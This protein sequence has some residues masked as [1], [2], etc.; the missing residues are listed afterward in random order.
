LKY[1][2]YEELQYTNFLFK[3]GEK[4]KYIYF[5][6]FGK[7]EIFCNQTVKNLCSM[8][9]KISQDYII[10]PTKIE[11]YTKI[12]NDILDRIYFCNLIKKEFLDEIE[13]KLLVLTD[14]CVL[15]MESTLNNLPYLYNVKILSEKCGYYKIE[16][17]NLLLLMK[18]VKDGK[19]IINHIKNSHLELILDRMVNICQKKVN[20]INNKSKLKKKKKYFFYHN[21]NQNKNEIKPKI[22]SNKIKDFLL[23]KSKKFKTSIITSRNEDNS[24]NK[25]KIKLY[26]LTEINKSKENR[27]NLNNLNK[28]DNKN[29]KSINKIIY[30][31]YLIKNNDSNKNYNF[32][33]NKFKSNIAN[34]K[35]A[36]SISPL[37][38]KPYNTI[39]VIRNN[40]LQEK[41]KKFSSHKTPKLNPSFNPIGIKY[42][43][44]MIKTLKN[45]LENELLFFSSFSKNEISRNAK[46]AF[47]ES[48]TDI[49]NFNRNKE[50]NKI[51]EKKIDKKPNIDQ[52]LNKNKSTKNINDLNFDFTLEI[53]TRKM[54]HL[55]RNRDNFMETIDSKD[56]STF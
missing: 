36:K 30:N 25:N 52:N 22:I 48:K 3:E 55:T 46:T 13:L 31:R 43:E 37:I 32:T 45:T 20:Y 1:F 42:E 24:F 4:N 44:N 39:N 33:I 16:Y 51:S 26:Y 21:Y 27:I 28:S 56:N 15:G 7:Y 40:N 11:E 54:S 49:R 29:M 23:D 38:N 14:R 10:N 19:E 18:E 9:Q 53:N 50:M 34:L 41:Y 5:L 47:T 17:N 12:T 2:T 8:I 35:E 6:K